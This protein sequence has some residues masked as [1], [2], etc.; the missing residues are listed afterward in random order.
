[1]HVQIKKWRRNKKWSQLIKLRKISKNAGLEKCIEYHDSVS[2]NVSKND[3]ERSKLIEEITSKE[4]KIREL[5]GSGT[6]RIRHQN[7]LGDVSIEQPCTGKLSQTVLR[8]RKEVLTI[9]KERERMEHKLQRISLRKERHKEAVRLITHEIVHKTKY[10]IKLE[11]Q[12]MKIKEDLNTKRRDQN[13][14][15]F[16]ILELQ[17][18]MEE[19]EMEKTKSIEH[20]LQPDSEHIN[21]ALFK[22]TNRLSVA[23]NQVPTTLFHITLYFA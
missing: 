12:L 20:G 2:D 11:D 5:Q 9:A 4:A 8:L 16:E 15:E 7:S 10:I 18:F 6:G 22:I 1:M 23:N 21:S 3:I 19:N 13:T 14:I 17:G